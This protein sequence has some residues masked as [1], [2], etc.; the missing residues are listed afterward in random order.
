MQID[1]NNSNTH[2][3]PDIV[4]QIGRSTGVVLTKR[5]IPAPSINIGNNISAGGDVSINDVAVRIDP[6]YS[7]VNLVESLCESLQELL[8]SQRV[9]IIFMDTHKQTKSILN[10]M[11]NVLWADSLESLVPL[12]LVVVDIF[13]PAKL[14]KKDS[15]W[16]PGAATVLNLPSV[17]D[18]PAREAAQDDI[19]TLALVNGLCGSREE[20]EGFAKAMLASHSDISSVHAGFALA[21]NGHRG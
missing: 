21:V 7:V 19:A 3:L 6:D 18:P 9:A 4:R 13:D 8:M 10:G 20:A 5:G 15:A 16:P 17:Y 11:A 12:G 2:Y 1:P 14:A